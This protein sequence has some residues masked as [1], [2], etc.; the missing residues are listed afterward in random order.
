MAIPFEKGLVET[1]DGLYAYLQP[2]GGWGWSNAGLITDGGQSLLVDTLFDASLTR[3][4]LGVM[5][6]A[7]GVGADDIGIIVNTH[8]NGCCAHAEVI[9]SAASARE[10]SELPA[11][12]L[13]AIMA[14]ARAMGPAG[15]YLVDIFGSFDF[16][17]VEE[18][19]PTQTFSGEYRLMVGDKKVDLIEV[20]PAHTAGDVLIHVPGDKTVFTGDILFIEGTPIMWAGPVGNWIAACDK[21]ISFK[22]ETIVPGHGPITDVHGVRRVQDYLRY[23]DQE[24][25]KRFDAG[26]SVRDAAH[27]IRLGDFSSWGDSERIAVN[28]STLYREYSGD[29]SPP[30]VVQ[31]FGLMA[32]LKQ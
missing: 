4:M 17:D 30:D 10:M 1:G 13:A 23:I 18:K 26:L 24:A 32:E 6:D 2:D 8:G 14:Q 29:T 19:L 15:Q 31:L 27:D 16:T 22:A 3:E 7:A 20:G 21:I 11:S 25:R 5:A 28:I 9:A 12:Q